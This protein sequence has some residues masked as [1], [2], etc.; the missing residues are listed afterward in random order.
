MTDHTLPERL[1]ELLAMA[2][3]LPWP[4]AD[5]S[6][7]GTNE[8]D[9]A[10]IVEAINALPTLLDALSLSA[11]RE[12]GG[13]L[14]EFM[15]GAGYNDFG[16]EGDYQGWPT[17]QT[18]VHFLKEYLAE[19]HPAEWPVPIPLATDDISSMYAP[20]SSVPGRRRV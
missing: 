18:A 8:S 13:P 9:A 2:T 1:R 20:G 3:P 6:L 19:L 16:K 10:L 14:I 7:R 17:E 5:R 12:A 15:R 11:D 4:N